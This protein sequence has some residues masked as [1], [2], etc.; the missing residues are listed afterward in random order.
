MLQA[1]EG[2]ETVHDRID[3][4]RAEPGH[5]PAAQLPGQS[6][7]LQLDSDGGLVGH[8]EAVLVQL[9]DQVDPGQVIPAFGVRLDECV[10]I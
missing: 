5:V 1:P 4:L 7:V 9:V 8:V 6:T 10:E 3:T 2:A